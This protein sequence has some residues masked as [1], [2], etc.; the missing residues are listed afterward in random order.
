MY[1]K[2]PKSSAGVKFW[3]YNT[4]RAGWCIYIEKGPT[5]ECISGPYRTNKDIRAA[6]FIHG[7]PFTFYDIKKNT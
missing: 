2:Y 7:V 3:D 4:L 6:E 1:T 5:I